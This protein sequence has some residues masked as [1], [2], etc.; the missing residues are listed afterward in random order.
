MTASGDYILVE[1]DSLGRFTWTVRAEG[2]QAVSP[3]P[4]MTL[5]FA[6]YQARLAW[7]ELNG[8]FS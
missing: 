6:V 5:D 2:Q 3:N 4:L 1:V 7:K 8:E